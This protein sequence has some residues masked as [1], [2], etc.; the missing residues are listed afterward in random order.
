MNGKLSPATISILRVV[1]LAVIVSLSI[2]GFGY[3]QSENTRQIVGEL[4]KAVV[5]ILVTG[6]GLGGYDVHQVAQEN[7]VSHGE[8]VKLAFQKS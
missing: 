8:A 1:A 4:V 2:V 6:L 7:N 5:P 3:A